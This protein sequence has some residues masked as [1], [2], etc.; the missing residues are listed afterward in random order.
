MSVQSCSRVAYVTF[1][2][3]PLLQSGGHIKL[4]THLSVG[5]VLDMVSVGHFDEARESH[6][7]KLI[8]ESS[9]DHCV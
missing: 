3:Q 8:Q 4:M 7:T 9:W 2:L 1:L 6:G 5:G